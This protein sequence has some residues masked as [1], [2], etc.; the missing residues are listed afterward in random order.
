LLIGNFAGTVPLF[1]LS[2]S[3]NTSLFPIERP[4]STCSLAK[5]ICFI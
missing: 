5:W 4:S 2:K 1:E 3:I